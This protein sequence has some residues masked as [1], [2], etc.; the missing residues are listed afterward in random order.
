M[1]NSNYLVTRCSS[2]TTSFSNKECKEYN[3]NFINDII[4][5]TFGNVNNFYIS[6][7]CSL[8]HHELVNAR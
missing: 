8:S 5:T 3:L 7:A 4:V 2:I 6:L 1:N